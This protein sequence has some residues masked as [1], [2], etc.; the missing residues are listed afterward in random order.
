MNKTEKYLTRAINKEIGENYKLLGE[1]ETF[2][3]ACSS[4]G[5][6][7]KNRNDILLTTYDIYRACKYLDMKP[8]DFLN[9][10]CEVYIGKNS[11]LPLVSIKFRES[12]N[13]D[14]KYTVCPF[15]RKK[16]EKG[17]CAIHQAK[18]FICL[19]HP[20]GRLTTLDENEKSYFM[21]S[22]HHC[23][24]NNENSKKYTLEEWFKDF[25]LETNQKFTDIYNKLLIDIVNI[26]DIEKFINNNKIPDIIK[27]S[28]LEDMIRLLYFR[29]DTSKNV[30]DVITEIRDNV[31]KNVVCY[32]HLL[33]VA[34]YN[35]KAKNYKIDNKKLEEYK[36]TIFKNE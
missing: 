15:N 8:V 23:G 33:C 13:T 25:D 28:F 35:I 4:C 22:K 31:I 17:I 2:N 7:C 1:G 18:P 14:N 19:A 9:K 12:L 3:F 16:D 10:Y 5:S 26:I 34:G 24:S 6:C 29:I 32:V 11:H 30:I 27:D 21:V 36:K 20:V